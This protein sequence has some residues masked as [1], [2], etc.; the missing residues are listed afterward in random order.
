MKVVLAVWMFVT[1][2]LPGAHAAASEALKARTQFVQVRDARI[3]YRVIGQGDPIVLATRLRGTL[4][5]WDPLFLDLLAQRYKVITFDY[6][7]VGYSSGVMPDDLSSMSAYV[8][9]FTRAIDVD[10]FA[11][12]GWSWGGLVAQTLAVD[13]PER[14]T[15][16]ILV[17]TNPPGAVPFPAKQAFLDRALKPVNDLADEEVL[18]FEPKSPASREAAKRSHDRI[19]ARPG[20][21]ERIPA[22]MEQFQIYF[23]AA[24][25][26][27]EDKVGLREQLQRLRTPMLIISGDNDPSTPGQ[28]WF[29]LM[30]QLLN[31]QLMMYS[32]T[33]HAPQHQHPELSTQ[34]IDTFLTLSR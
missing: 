33:G 22:R 18:F 29:P 21:T 31:A 11:V 28:N 30:G 16:V 12:L 24:Q 15:A 9:E 23:K 27:R 10:K 2:L 19:Y 3:A 1:I 34:H 14:V 6:P 17:G 8:E 26:F 13:L 4:D 5:T 25:A 7:G 20:V 32:L